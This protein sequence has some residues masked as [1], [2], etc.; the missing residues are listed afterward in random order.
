[1]G[2]SEEEG[3]EVE[4]PQWL[5]PPGSARFPAPSPVS[6]RKKMRLSQSPQSRKFMTA[7]AKKK[8]KKNCVPPRG[9]ALR[10]SSARSLRCLSSRRTTKRGTNR[11]RG[12]PSME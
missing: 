3:E 10:I 11:R 7:A 9:G 1:M 4:R 6:E 8:K 5:A 12:I 2:S